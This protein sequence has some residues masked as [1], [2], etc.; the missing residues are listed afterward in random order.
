MITDEITNSQAAFA[1]LEAN[2]LRLMER[3]KPLAQ[4]MP[5]HQ[6]AMGEAAPGHQTGHS[7]DQSAHSA[8]H[9]AE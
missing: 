9:A 3:C 4:V 5:L 8:G 7:F 6:Q 2:V 1:R